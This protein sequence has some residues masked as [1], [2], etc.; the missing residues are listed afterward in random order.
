MCDGDG[1]SPAVKDVQ[2]RNEPN[3]NVTAIF[4]LLK[5]QRDT[6]GGAR[7]AKTCTGLTQSTPIT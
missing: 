4:E 5:L 2:Q 1:E 7:H 3:V 6:L